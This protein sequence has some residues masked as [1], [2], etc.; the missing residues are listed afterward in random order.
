MTRFRVVYE[1]GY[2]SEAEARQAFRAQMEANRESAKDRLL[3]PWE[4][5][6]QGVIEPVPE[7]VRLSDDPV[8]A[9]WVETNANLRDWTLA[10]RVIQRF[11]VV[12]VMERGGELVAGEVARQAILDLR[13]GKTVAT[14][15]VVRLA[16]QRLETE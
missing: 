11:P 7:Q 3:Q 12:E 5:P 1:S 4:R 16:R 2:N 10:M 6:T 14:S 13:A 9:Q 15:I 8:L